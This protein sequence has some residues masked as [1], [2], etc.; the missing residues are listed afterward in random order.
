MKI[1]EEVGI[2]Q[3]TVLAYYLF[4]YKALRLPLALTLYVSHWINLSSILKSIFNTVKSWLIKTFTFFFRCMSSSCF[5]QEMPFPRPK[6]QFVTGG[7][8]AQDTSRVVTHKLIISCLP[9]PQWSPGGAPAGKVKQHSFTNACNLIVNTTMPVQTDAP[10][11]AQYDA[12]MLKYLV[13]IQMENLCFNFFGWC[14]ANN[15]FRL[16]RP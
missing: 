11:F 5:L 7:A 10:I 8:R 2:Y 1:G 6:I 16:F 4:Q 12:T 9:P 14:G 3:Q 13:F 15:A